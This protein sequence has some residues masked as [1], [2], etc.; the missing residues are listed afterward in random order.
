MEQRAGEANYYLG[1]LAE[2]RADPKA[3]LE[4]YRQ[5]GTGYEFVPAQARVSAIL[6]EDGFWEE[7]RENL[8]RARLQQPGK[9]RQLV[10][11]EAQLLADRGLEGEVL[12]SL[13]MRLWTI[14]KMLSS[15]I[16][17]Q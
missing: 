9:A 14:R 8:Q 16:L 15:F 7:A 5:A 2:R 17:E 3:A 1:S 11:V 12:I 13:M 6:V 4:H 10:M